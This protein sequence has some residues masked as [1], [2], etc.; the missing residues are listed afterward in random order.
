[1]LSFYDKYKQQRF[2]F[3]IQL[4]FFCALVI[5]LSYTTNQFWHNMLS[6]RWIF[7]GYFVATFAILPKEIFFAFK[8]DFKLHLLFALF[9]VTSF[10]FNGYFELSYINLSMTVTVIRYF[11]SHQE[12]LR[13]KDFFP[14]LLC[15]LLALAIKMPFYSWVNV[16]LNFGLGNPNHV[17]YLMTALFFLFLVHKRYF[18]SLLIFISLCI[19]QS[20]ASLLATGFAILFALSLSSR[21]KNLMLK[22]NFYQVIILPVIMFLTYV[23]IFYFALG[24]RNAEFEQKLKKLSLNDQGENITLEPPDAFFLPKKRS[25]YRFSNKIFD[26]SGYAR[27]LQFK[28]LKKDFFTYVVIGDEN[29]FVDRYIWTPHNGVLGAVVVFG[30]LATLIYIYFLNSVLGGGACFT[31]PFVPIL[32][33]D[34]PPSFFGFYFVFMILIAFICAR[35]IADHKSTV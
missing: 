33:Y 22:I 12:W 10:I 18:I 25:A 17:A 7:L 11:R 34:T 32:S 5:P 14:F 23:S 20:Y 28:G 21:L 1:M 16:R 9:M 13:F 24:S 15:C 4:L 35:S 27:V 30:L 29:G 3:S 19:I 31:I 2:R 26:L 8:K 6:I